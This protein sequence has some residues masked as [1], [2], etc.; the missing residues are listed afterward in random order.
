ME[1]YGSVVIVASICV[2]NHG[3][4]A[5]VDCPLCFSELLRLTPR[6]VLRQ[7]DEKFYDILK[8]KKSNVVQFHICC[9]FLF[10]RI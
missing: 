4:Q 2:P 8:G 3:K 5:S 9:D 7:R 6:E 1:L 10:W